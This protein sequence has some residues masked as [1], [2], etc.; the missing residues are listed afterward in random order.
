MAAL[1]YT[2]IGRQRERASWRP[3]LAQ[4]EKLLE[5]ARETY[6]GRGEFPRSFLQTP[7]LPGAHHIQELTTASALCREGTRMHHCVY[8]YR[9][10]C[11][12]GHTAIFSVR[13]ENRSL[14]TLEVHPKEKRIAQVRGKRNR[15]PTSEEWRLVDVFARANGLKC[16]SYVR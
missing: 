5:E 1:V 15:W 6:A 12:T 16:L 11:A 9:N 8:E 2:F 3:G 13:R 7:K 4:K 14:L 10:A